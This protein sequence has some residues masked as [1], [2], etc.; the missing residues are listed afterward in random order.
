MKVLILGGGGMLGHKLCQVFSKQFDT[1]VT[2]RKEYGVYAKYQIFNPEKLWIKVHVCNFDGIMRTFAEVKPDVVVNCIGVIKQV[3]EAKDPIIS[4]TINSLFPHR[5][6]ELCA[7]NGARLIH[8]STDCVFSGRKGGYTETDIP[9]AEDL[10]GR[11]KLLGE[12]NRGSCLT[13]RTSIIGRELEKRTGLL[14]WF[15]GRKE[16][17]VRGYVNAIFSG[18]TTPA[19]GQIMADLIVNHKDLSGV[20]HISSDP[21]SKYELLMRLRES[22][23]LDVEIEPFEKYYCDRSLDSS[24]FRSETGFIPPSWDKMIEELKQDKTPYDNWRKYNDS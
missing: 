1:Y 3:P 10:Y 7:M 20:Y 8:V 12:V 11:T 15:L 19:L 24:R 16:Q 21:I 14:E 22:F 13:I 17:R 2:V 4:L 9:D 6:A 23:G 18:F 5:I